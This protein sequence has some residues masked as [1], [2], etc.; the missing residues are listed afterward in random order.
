MAESS[1]TPEQLAEMQKLFIQFFQENGSDIGEGAVRELTP[2]ELTDDELKAMTIPAVKYRVEDG[3]RTGPTNPEEWVQTS[4]AAMMAPLL[5][6]KQAAD[7]SAEAANQ[8]ALNAEGAE[9]VNAN[10]SVNNDGAVILT[11]TDRNNQ[12]VRKEVGFR[13]AKTYS[14][15][16]AMVADA[17]NVEEGRFVMIASTTEPDN[18]QMYVKGVSAF[19]YVCDLS[20]AQGIKGD[21]G[22]MRVGSVTTLPAGQPV[23]ITNSGT[24]SDAIFNFSIPQGD[25]GV[26]GIQGERGE[27]GDRGDKGEG[28]DYSTLTDEEKDELAGY[29]VRQVTSDNILG[30]EYDVERRTIVYPITSGVQYDPDRRCIKL[31]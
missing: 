31:L 5:R 28:I 12:Q 27:K 4:L 19:V 13:I 11:V 7:Q 16:E 15:Y 10:L 17:I 1:F 29:V 20:G 26:Q 30:P 22:T 24:Q 2:E 6:S 18:G 21:S 23:I 14:S 9:Y 3:Q 8:A 25:Q